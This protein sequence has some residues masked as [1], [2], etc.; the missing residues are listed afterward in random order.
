MMIQ[1]YLILWIVLPL[2]AQIL[3]L[4]PG[5]VLGFDY[6]T[7]KGDIAEVFLNI[8]YASP[9]VNELRFE[10]TKPIEQWKDIRNG[11]TL[12]PA[13]LPVLPGVGYGVAPTSEDCLTLNIIRPKKKPPPSGFAVLFY[14]HGGGYQFGSAHDYGYKGFADIYTPQDVIVVII[15]YRL[16]VYGFFSTGDERMPGN[17]GLFD[18]AEALKFVHSNADRFGGDLSRITVCGQSSGGAAAGQLILSPITRDYVFGSIEMSGSPWAVYAIGPFVTET[19]LKLAKVKLYKVFNIIKR[20]T[21]I[22]PN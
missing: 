22:N 19:S 6:E 8:P 21:P 10:K 14:V 2:S 13:C 1:V 18:M 5:K 7:K 4:K 16:G 15:Q 3:E 17:L 9:P 12:G 20:R 11:T